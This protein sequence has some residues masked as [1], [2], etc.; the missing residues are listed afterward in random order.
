MQIEKAENYRAKIIA[1]L[2]TEK[3]PTD[4][5]PQKL[6]NFVIALQDDEVIGVAGIE[7]YDNY[8]LLRS[9]AVAADYRG[10]GIANQLL[11]NLERLDAAQPLREIYLLTETAPEYFSNKG[12][13]KITRAQVP[14]EVQQST[15]FSHV[16]PQSAIV[17][18]KIL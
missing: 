11:D 1:L 12:Y 4:D 14:A 16:C 3:L 7:I 13:Q 17:M 5:L 8:G 18:K 6:E 15:E 2:A 9:V 10:K